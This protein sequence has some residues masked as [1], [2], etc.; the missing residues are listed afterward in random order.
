VQIHVLARIAEVLHT[1]LSTLVPERSGIKEPT[2]D[3]KIGKLP[4]L[5]QAWV[6][7]VIATYSEE[8]SDGAKKLPS[9]KESKRTVSGGEGEVA[10]RTSG[11]VGITRR[12]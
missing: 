10:A 5:A 9:K 1:N 12:R 7:R 3:S 2:V 11:H 6:K 4:E 8:D